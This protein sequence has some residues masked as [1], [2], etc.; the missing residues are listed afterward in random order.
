MLAEQ[1]TAR[2][3]AILWVLFDTGMRATEICA[4]RLGDVDLE[5]GIVSVQEKGATVRRLTLGHEGLRHLLAYLDNYRLGAAVG[6]ERTDEDSLF[7]SEADRP[8]TKS[9]ITLLFDRLKQRAGITRK[10]VGPALLRESFAMRYL[11]TGGDLDALW[12]LL[13]QKES[14][15]PQLCHL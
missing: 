5:Q 8:L 4:L 13:G 7:L 3:R 15:L 9:R 12:E 14:L 11:Q 2:N 1:A 6:G 10:G